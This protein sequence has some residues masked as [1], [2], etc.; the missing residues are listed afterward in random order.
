M[1]RTGCLALGLAGVGGQRGQL[2]LPPGRGPKGLAGDKGISRISPGSLPSPSTPCS[3]A[4]ASGSWWA[5]CPCLPQ[6]LS[7]GVGMVAPVHRLWVSRGVRSCPEP[8]SWPDPTGGGSVGPCPGAGL[9]DLEVQCPGL[10][11]G[12]WELH[13]LPL[14]SIPK[15]SRWGQCASRTGWGESCQAAWEGECKG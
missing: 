6:V 14:L 8:T 11:G 15:S 9:Q 1:V 3:A 4:G 2:A 12:R 13:P 7:R 5:S 10:P